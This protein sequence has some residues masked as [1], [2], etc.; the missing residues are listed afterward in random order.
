MSGRLGAEE[1]VTSAEYVGFGVVIAAV[2]VVLFALDPSPA[3]R[4]RSLVDDQVCDVLR[5]DCEGERLPGGA[6]RSGGG[7]DSAGLQPGGSGG[8]AGGKDASGA[9]VGAVAGESRADQR[10]ARRDGEAGRGGWWLPSAHSG[11]VAP[12]G[13]TDDWFHNQRA[14]AAWMHDTT[15]SDTVGIAERGWHLLRF[16]LNTVATVP[17]LG[18]SL[19]NGQAAHPARG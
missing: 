17:A 10:R 11:A 18:Y 15:G 6:G 14:V 4:L 7:G 16:G 12:D 13:T 8:S 3:D 1:G 19:L 9:A 5:A 2:I